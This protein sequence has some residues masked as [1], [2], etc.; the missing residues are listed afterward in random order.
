[1]ETKAP[2][3]TTQTQPST[4]INPERIKKYDRMN[5]R[6][7]FERKRM[8]LMNYNPNLQE[9]DRANIASILG[10]YEQ[11]KLVK[12]DFYGLDVFLAPENLL[13]QAFASFR[14]LNYFRKRFSQKVF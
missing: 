5:H 10:M 9:P 8:F 11:G 6:R 2:A 1:M 7:F 13:D 3:K 14:K 4:Q 12:K